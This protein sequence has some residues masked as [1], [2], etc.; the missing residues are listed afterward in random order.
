MVE[1]ARDRAVLGDEV[2]ADGE[3]L[4]CPLDLVAQRAI[5]RDVGKRD[6]DLVDKGLAATLSAAKAGSC[7]GG[8]SAVKMTPSLVTFGAAGGVRDVRAGA[9]RSFAA[10]SG[11][12]LVDE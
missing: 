1:R 6:R 11:G 9:A 4:E 7:S 5:A 2:R 3:P 12:P 10:S 8:R